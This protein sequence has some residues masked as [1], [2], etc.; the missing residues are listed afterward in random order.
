MEDRPSPSSRTWDIHSNIE[1]ILTDRIQ[2][3]GARLHTGR[4]RNDQVVTDVR[5]FLRDATLDTIEAIMMLEKGLME[6]AEV[7][8]DVILP[9]FTHVQH[10]QP[11][12]VGH[13]MM[14]HLQRLQRDAE[15][16]IDSYKRLNICPLGSAALA[17]TTYS[18]DRTYTAQLLGFEAPCANSIDG[19]SDRDFVASTSSPLL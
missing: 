15:R 1:F 6:R 19:V 16:F 9:G 7:Y 14:A 4:S 8:R 17:G 10:A 2:D 5:M 12:T 13:W 18:I 3:A 11:V